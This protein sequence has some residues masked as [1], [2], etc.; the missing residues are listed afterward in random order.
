MVMLD[1]ELSSERQRPGEAGASD[2]AEP[3]EG[4]PLSDL[5]VA[6][7]LPLL[8]SAF[9]MLTRPIAFLLEEY[10]RLGPIFRLRAAHHRFTVLAGVEA[11]ALLA[12][13]ADKYLA[14]EPSWGAFSTSFGARCI[15]PGVDGP[16]HY[17][18]RKIQQQ[19]YSRAAIVRRLP[20]AAAIA[21]RTFDRFAAGP[22]A[23]VPMCRTIVTDQ[24][25]MLTLGR[26]PGEYLDDVVRTIRFAMN[27]H[28]T[29]RWPTAMMRLPRF[30]RARERYFE[31]ARQI[32]DAHAA[33]RL[34]SEL[35]D[36]VRDAARAEPGFLTETEMLMMA[37]GPFVA[38]LDTVANTTA[39]LLHALL[40]NPEAYARAEA[41]A[42]A[43][44][45]DPAALTPERLD[46]A[47]ALRG[48]FQETIRL[49]PIGP[50]L[51][52]HVAQP[53][54]FAGYRLPAGEPVLFA[55]TMLH[56]MPEYFPDPY[57]FDID[58]NRD[59]GGKIS[60]H[61]S[62]F[63]LGPHTCLG[64]GFAEVQTMLIAATLLRHARFALEPGVRSPRLQIDPSLTLGNRYNVRMVARRA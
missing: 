31:L 16:R 63:G 43:L 38:G 45:A 40:R 30:R 50:M 54:D 64:A 1:A 55:T 58:R 24:L 47:P 37:T 25:G 39:F 49:Y 56:V 13:T 62:A 5:P 33:G 35:L 57:R 42:D 51:Y 6:R 52:R 4:R 21:R 19:A 8:G 3:S 32:L 22:V 23:L 61:I 48:A 14:A 46:G 2:R 9:P 20:E 28:V 41:D 18:L 7:G 11:N 53:V 36:A 26:G 44:L 10:R 59:A 12:R 29:H 27:C 17:R 60:S 15:M 34:Q